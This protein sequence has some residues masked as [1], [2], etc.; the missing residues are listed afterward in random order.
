MVKITKCPSA[1][2]DVFFQEH[3]FDEGLGAGIDPQHYEK[4]GSN[5]HTKGNKQ[6]HGNKVAASKRKKLKIAEASLEGH[7]NKAEIMK[8]LK[9][10]YSL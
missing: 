10:K 4:F 1:P 7:E 8:I 5:L 2:Q 9:D 3:Q 6:P